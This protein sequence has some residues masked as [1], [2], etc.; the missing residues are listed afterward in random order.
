MRAVALLAS[1]LVAGCISGEPPP[2]PW[3]DTGTADQFLGP[4]VLPEVELLIA[5]PALAELADQPREYVKAQ[6]VYQGETY[7]PV[8]VHLKGQNSFQTLDGKPSLRIKIDEYIEGQTFF[9]LKDL[10]FD[11][12]VSDP[13]MMHERLAYQVAREAGLPAS[14][15]NHLVLTINGAPYGL[16]ANV[17]T[18]KKRMIGRFFEDNDGPLFKATDVDFTAELVPGYELT[19]G[20]DDRALLDG[21]ATALTIA[22]PDAALAAASAYV[23]LDHFRRFWAMESVIGQFDS[24]PYSNP[25]DDYYVYADPTTSKL[26]FLPTGMDESFSAADFSPMQIHSALAARC[27]ESQACAQAYV[28][29]TWAIVELTEAIGLEQQRADLEAAIAPYAAADPRRPYDDAALTEGQTQ[30]GYFIRGRRQTIGS[31][32]PPPSP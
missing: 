2:P 14:R 32:L 6:L 15:S 12:M 31:F 26:W 29:E 27:L 3:V 4:D 13:S 20:D 11:N 28:N 5:A 7:G 19:S 1:L 16:Y 10:T 21:L 25:G 24:F 30:L 17:E 23:D 18:V 8:G 22:D 9:G